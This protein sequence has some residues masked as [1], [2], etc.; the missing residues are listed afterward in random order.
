MADKN[1]LIEVFQDTENWCRENVRLAEAVRNS[2]EKTALYA[3]AAYPAVPA[4]EKDAKTEI[5][6]SKSR[7]FE[8]AARLLRECPGKKVAVHNFASAKNPGGGVTW[9]SRAQEECLCR[10][11]TLYP[12][13]NTKKLWEQYYCF[14]RERNDPRYTDACIYSPGILIVKSDTELPERLPESEWREVDVIT[15]AAPSLREQSA[16]PGYPGRVSDEELLELHRQRGRHMLSIAAAH[17]A[18]A[19]VL[20]A[21]GC[22]AFLNN[23]VIVAQAYREILPEFEGC[24]SRIEFAVYCPPWGSANYEV[25]QKFFGELK[26]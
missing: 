26:N 21:F 20:G 2:I 4:P 5:T 17:G 12:V 11:S 25:F 8:A 6:V 15:C 24:F 13:L 9:G 19:L 22:G 18:E 1:Q 10:C 3:A 23:P 7:S 16:N 14:H